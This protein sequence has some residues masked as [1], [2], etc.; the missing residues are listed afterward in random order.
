MS[1]KHEIRPQSHMGAKLLNTNSK[2]KV[3]ELGGTETLKSLA[4]PIYTRTQNFR[5]FYACG[6]NF[7]IYIGFI[8]L[9]EL[10]KGLWD[11][12]LSV[13]SRTVNKKLFTTTVKNS[14]T[15]HGTIK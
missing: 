7:N 12:T 2:V 4:E 9:K 3:T 14:E 5:I 6:G 10:T 11:S 1:R 15:A 13:V 8:W